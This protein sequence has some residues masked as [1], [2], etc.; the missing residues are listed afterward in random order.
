[1]WI[2]ACGG[3]QVPVLYS[4]V[5]TFTLLLFPC[6]N[7]NNKNDSF[8]M[9]LLRHVLQKILSSGRFFEADICQCKGYTHKPINI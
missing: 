6:C 1:M 7:K 3:Y 4:H 8:F 5:L 2:R 9:W